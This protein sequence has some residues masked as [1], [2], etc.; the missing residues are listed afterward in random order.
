MTC[1]LLKCMTKSTVGKSANILEAATASDGLR[2]TSNRIP[3][4]RQDEQTTLGQSWFNRCFHSRLV[5]SQTN[6]SGKSKYERDRAD[7]NLRLATN[8]P[9]NV[10]CFPTLKISGMSEWSPNTTDCW[11]SRWSANLITC[12][13]LA[14][15]S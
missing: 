10:D 11:F 4:P 1:S 15:S 7:V 12:G 3:L 2:V 14:W 5:L 9:V 8:H 13:K 6:D